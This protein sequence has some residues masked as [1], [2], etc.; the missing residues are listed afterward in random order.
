MINN[1]LKAKNQE[2]IVKEI[3]N[4]KEDFINKEFLRMIVKLYPKKVSSVLSAI[5]MATTYNH[6]DV[7]H[8]AEDLFRSEIVGPFHGVPALNAALFLLKYAGID[9]R[10]LRVYFNEG[11]TGDGEV[12]S[13]FYMK[14]KETATTTR[15]G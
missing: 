14:L 1:V 6:F 4:S 8:A 5:E 11:K 3:L 7:C 2:D 15:K 9:K 12:V 13:F 10:L